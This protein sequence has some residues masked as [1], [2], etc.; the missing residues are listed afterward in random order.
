MSNMR[1][2]AGLRRARDH[3]VDALRAGMDVLRADMNRQLAELQMK[4]KMEQQ[5]RRAA[6]VFVRLRV[7]TNI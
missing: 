7:E 5:K 2:V 3:G 4:L 1:A 6:E